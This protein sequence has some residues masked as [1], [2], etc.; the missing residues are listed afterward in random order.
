MSHHLGGQVMVPSPVCRELLIFDCC[1]VFVWEQKVK[2][3]AD[4]YDVRVP[5][6][7]ADVLKISATSLSSLVS[8]S[9]CL[10]DF[11]PHHSSVAHDDDGNDGIILILLARAL[12]GTCVF[13]YEI[14]YV[15][16]G[17]VCV[18][19]YAGM[20]VLS[21]NVRY[22]PSCFKH[23]LQRCN[24]FR[25]IGIASFAPCT[26]AGQN[27]MMNYQGGVVGYCC[28]EAALSLNC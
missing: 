11:V 26:R 10:A 5:T 13:V 9:K 21:D 16:P 22:V 24:T 25:R 4:Q 12:L 19:M 20:W 1:L 6:Y 14:D 8:F 3:P 2:V 15:M 17:C 23:R 27:Q 7:C 18:C 28:Q